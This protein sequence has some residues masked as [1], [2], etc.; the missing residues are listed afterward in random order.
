VSQG[1]VSEH[2]RAIGKEQE[3]DDKISAVG[4]R[5]TTVENKITTIIDGSDGDSLSRLRSELN[6][7][8]ITRG[9][10]DFLIRGQISDIDTRISGID[11]RIDGVNAEISRIDQRIAAEENTARTAEASLQSTINSDLVHAADYDPNRKVISF[12]N[13]NGEEIDTVDCEAFVHDGMIKDVEIVTQDNTKYLDIEWNT[14]GGGKHI[15]LPVGDIVNHTGDG[16]S[17]TAGDGINIEEDV[18]SVK[19]YIGERSVNAKLK[20]LQQMLAQMYVL[21]ADVY[22]KDRPQAWSNAPIYSFDGISASEEG[23][24]TIAKGN[25]VVISNG[26]F[27]VISNNNEVRTN[28]CYFIT[29]DETILSGGYEVQENAGIMAIENQVF[30]SLLEDDLVRNDIC[31]LIT[32]Q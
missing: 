7:E 10:E 32:M 3:L 11:N 20:I 17:L 22:D 16:S 18:I 30:N 4:N 1:L 5:V 24:S 9:N 19:D 31:Y 12:K 14:D 8:V 2:N 13:I 6:E 21:K 27:N 23:E 25:L 15:Q 28:V 26:M 29:D